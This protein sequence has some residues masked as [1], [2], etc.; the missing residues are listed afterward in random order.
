M[1]HT[2]ELIEAKISMKARKEKIKKQE[3]LEQ[4]VLDR[5]SCVSF[6]LLFR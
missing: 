6:S 5:F 4:L 3:N 1:T 2:H